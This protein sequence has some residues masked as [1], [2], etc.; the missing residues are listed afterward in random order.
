[1]N[2]LEQKGIIFNSVSQEKDPY[3]MISLTG[4]IYNNCMKCSDLNG[5][6]G[7]CSRHQN[8]VGERNGV[9]EKDE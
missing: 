6:C 7:E 8:I 5:S 3:R 9:E 2:P 1:M 4:G